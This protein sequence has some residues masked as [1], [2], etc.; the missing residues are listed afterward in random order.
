MSTPW[1]GHVARTRVVVANWTDVLHATCSLLLERSK[2]MYQTKT[3]TMHASV[4][5]P[6]DEPW[7]H[8]CENLGGSVNNPSG[9]TVSL[10]FIIPTDML[11]LCAR[12]ARHCLDDVTL[13]V[14]RS[15]GE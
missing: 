15:L 12:H 8:L 11:Q 1:K 13:C 4:D 2:K 7:K 3:T 5:T 10:R 9:H 6:E 14:R